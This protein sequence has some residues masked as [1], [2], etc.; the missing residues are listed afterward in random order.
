[1]HGTTKL[2]LAMTAL[3]GTSLS[4]KSDAEFCSSALASLVSQVGEYAPTTPANI[5]SYI[6]ASAAPTVPIPTTIDFQWHA[7]ELCSIGSVLPTSLVPEFKSFAQ[8]LLQFGR[9][10]ESEFVFYI[11]DCEP[12]NEVASMTSA[13]HSYF[14]ATDNPCPTTPAPG[15]SSS[16]NYPTTPAATAT[17]SPNFNGTYTTSFVTAAAARP[18]GALLGAAAGILGAAAML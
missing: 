7:S 13:L 3:A 15:A 14:T 8:G 6:S 12:Q 17:S 16:G 5:L 9:D 2:L 11:T 1:M 4:Q 18:T 10:H